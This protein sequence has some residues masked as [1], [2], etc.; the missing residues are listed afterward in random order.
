MEGPPLPGHGGGGGVNI[1]GGEEV[2]KEQIFVISKV[3][4]LA[5]PGK[6]KKGTQ[7]KGATLKV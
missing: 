1:S 6:G 4:L 7:T 3:S 2:N 5:K